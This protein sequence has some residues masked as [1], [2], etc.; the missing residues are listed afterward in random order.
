M[1]A[2]SVTGT[3]NGSV[4]MG[5]GPGNGRNQFTSLLD[6]HVVF[7][8][9]VYMSNG[10]ETVSLPSNVWDLPEKLTILC[11]GKAWGVYKNLN[12]DGLVISFTV[13]GVKKRDVDFVIVKS[14]SGHFVEGDYDCT[15]C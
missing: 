2:S 14:P 12:S 15:H 4:S 3:G 11:A 5:R 7:H 10:N 1:G 8:G 6:P 13:N 9:T